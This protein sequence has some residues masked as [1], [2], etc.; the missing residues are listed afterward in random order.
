M[1]IRTSTILGNVL[2][3]LEQNNLT[4]VISVD[5][6]FNYAGIIKA[7]TNIDAHV[8][9][10]D[11]FAIKGRHRSH[12]KLLTDTMQFTIADHA[13]V[14]D[15][16]NRYQSD[17]PSNILDAFKSKKSHDFLGIKDKKRGKK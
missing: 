10:L 17:I 14:G 4:P 13:S 16:I 8:S 12:I 6:L 3:E 11:I 15:L 1:K 5:E 7:E 9:G 2:I